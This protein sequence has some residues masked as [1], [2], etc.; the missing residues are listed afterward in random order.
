MGSRDY[1]HRE[2]KKAKKDS[3][4]LSPATIIDTT[5][6]VEVIRKGKKRE[7]EEP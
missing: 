1:R 3:K 5:P 2:A 6:P 7:E 4:K